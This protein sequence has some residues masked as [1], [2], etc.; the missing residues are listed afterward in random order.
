[1][2]RSPAH[3]G[4]NTG[5]VNASQLTWAITCARCSKYVDCGLECDR[6]PVCLLYRTRLCRQ[7]Y[8]LSEGPYVVVLLTRKSEMSSHFRIACPECWKVYA[9]DGGVRKHI[10]LI[11]GRLYDAVNRTTVPFPTRERLDQAQH[12]YRQAQKHRAQATAQASTGATT[13]TVPVTRD[14]D[15]SCSTESISGDWFGE[16]REVDLADLKKEPLDVCYVL[17]HIFSLT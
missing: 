16:V 5:P 9:S 3:F 12:Q 14:T 15:G 13:E 6:Y 2:S 8:L 4:V 10:V 7:G 17:Y 11:H 1:M